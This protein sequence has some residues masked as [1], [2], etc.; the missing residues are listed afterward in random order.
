[1]IG[2]STLV[3]LRYVYRI[4]V[5]LH[6]ICIIM[7]SHAHALLSASSD[8]CRHSKTKSDKESI[9]PLLGSIARY[10][11]FI[12]TYS[13]KNKD[14]CGKTYI[15]SNTSSTR[16][17][18]PSIPTASFLSSISHGTHPAAPIPALTSR[19]LPPD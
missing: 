19:T 11:V 18:P 6:C 16:S 13:T 1:M 10:Q 12:T 7:E 2:L 15:S 5:I 14:N 8:A 4:V 9:N 3:D 17:N